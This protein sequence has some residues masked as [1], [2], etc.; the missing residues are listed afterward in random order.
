MQL[1]SHDEKQEAFVPPRRP[2]LVLRSLAAGSISIVGVW[3][4]GRI[5]ALI[6]FPRWIV[7]SDYGHRLCLL[8]DERNPK[9]IRSHVIVTFPTGSGF[10]RG[11]VRILEKFPL[12]SLY[13]GNSFRT[14]YFQ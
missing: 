10:P 12:V 11:F 2:L 6:P 14:T 7:L 1:K 3:V 4:D 13:F 9:R 5:R 8:A